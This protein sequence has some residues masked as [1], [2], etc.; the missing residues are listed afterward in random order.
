ML[1][2]ELPAAA[3]AV[4]AQSSVNT[5]DDVVMLDGMHADSD[6]EE[7]TE[8]GVGGGGN[9]EGLQ[10][11]MDDFR[12]SEDMYFELDSVPYTRRYVLSF[13]FY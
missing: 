1:T 9:L 13:V 10:A 7:D 4:L 8:G 12:T 6:N 11:E 5:D 2:A 3:R